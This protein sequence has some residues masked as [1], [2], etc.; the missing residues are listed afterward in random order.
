[1]NTNDIIQ[2]LQ[3]QL[4]VSC[5]ASDGDAFRDPESM[6]RFARAALDGGAAGIR[7]NGADDVRAIRS[8]TNVPILAI[9]KITMDDG[10]ILITPSFD[11][12]RRL[13][14]AGADIIAVDCTAR[15]QHHGALDRLRQLKQELGIPV[16]ADIATMEEAVAATKAGA[17]VVLSTMRGYTAETEQITRFDPEFITA[18]TRACPVP[19]I[20]EGRIN[21]EEDAREAITAGAFAVVV[22]TAITRPHEITRKFSCAIQKERLRA[23]SGKVF[24]G[25]DL[26]GTNT[27]FG[28]VS[29]KGE[30][31][32]QDSMPTPAKSGRDVLLEHLKRIAQ[33]A[34]TRAK[35]MDL[36]AL[37]LGIAT[38]GWVD[39]N[40]GQIAYATDNLPGWTGAPVGQE[41][42]SA[43]GL[44]VAVEND[45]NALAVAEKHFGAGR[46]LQHFV[47]ITFGTG[48]GGG[49]YIDGKLNRGSHFF[50][51]AFG[52]MTLVPQGV[53]CNCG[54]RGCF[55]VYCNAAALLRYAGT[56]DG[57]AEDVITAAHS[58]DEAAS[59]AISILASYA[60][61]GCASLVQLLDPEALILSGGLVQNNSIMMDAIQRELS[62]LVPTWGLRN[63]QVLAS[64]LGYYGGVLGAAAIAMEKL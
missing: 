36:S 61:Q 18:L 8:I 48:V 54:Q 45:A 64:P 46:G 32:D 53:P 58:G 49:A 47:C 33:V 39:W 31:L 17:D 21:T 57:T 3:G 42:A 20:A 6:A 59:S 43:V 12:A 63:L 16:A 4:I 60:A 30:L 41:V 7:A 29:A 14:E 24:L 52:H 22:G 40:T 62:V 28:I 10:K 56:H 15:G 27:K 19:V 23:D 50:A 35:A 51:N 55:E 5:Q 44:P 25:I 38:A 37:A 34:A 13:V 1:M 9:E 11:G 26:G 2:K